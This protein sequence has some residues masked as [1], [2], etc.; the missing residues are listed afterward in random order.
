MKSRSNCRNLLALFALVAA[1]IPTSVMAQ[2]RTAG[3]PGGPP[4]E[5]VFSIQGGL[6]FTADPDTFLLEAEGNYSFGRGV[7][8]GPAMQLGLSD[9]RVLLSPMVYA[10]YGFDLRR[11]DLGELRRLTPYVQAGPGL[12]YIDHD[13]RGRGRDRD[14]VGFLVSFG[15]GADYPI[16]EHLD[17]GTRVLFN[18]LP[19]DVLGENFYFS[20]QLAALR[21]RF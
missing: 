15:F 16:S 6:G 2:S 14:D 7:S 11:T 20:W 8:F 18:I 12:T 1:F 17:L 4:P 10:R 19:S 21:Y 13:G 5:G 3:R 9:N